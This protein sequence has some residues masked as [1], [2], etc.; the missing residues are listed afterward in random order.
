[1]VDSM[2]RKLAVFMILVGVVCLGGGCALM[3]VQDDNVAEKTDTDVGNQEK[4]ISESDLKEYTTYDNYQLQMSVSVTSENNTLET[5]NVS[6]IDVKN[7]IINTTITA[8]GTSEYIY[9]DLNNKIEYYSND[10][11]SWN[12]NVN[13]TMN[14]PDFSKI[15]TKVKNLEGI[16]K[17][18]NGSYNYVTSVTTDTGTFENIPVV[19][20]FSND[21]YIKSI[22]YDLSST[23]TSL[24]NYVISY[25]FTDV[26]KNSDVVIPQNIIDNATAGTETT[27]ISYISE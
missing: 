25:F 13:D 26:N 24:S 16:S 21:G 2:K 11:N 9:F 18:G 10:Q 1:M 6:I 3:F 27:T 15:I 20:T 4:V 17:T 12:K 19:V 5:N 23:D 22:S 8:M 14:L 7:K